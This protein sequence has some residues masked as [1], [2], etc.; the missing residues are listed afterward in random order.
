MKSS[1][2]LKL[3][4]LSLLWGGSFYFNEIALRE[5]PVFSVVAGRVV[6]AA[7]V[8]W[9]AALAS[10]YEVPASARDWGWFSVMAVVNNVIPFSLIVY[11]QTTITAG[12]ASILNATTPLFIVLVIALFIRNESIGWLKVAGLVVGFIGVGLM[13]GPEVLESDN[14]GVVGQLAILLAA[15]SYAVAGI[16]GRRFH[17]AS[18]P[19]IVAAAGQVTMSAVILIPVAMMIDGPDHLAAASGNAWMAVAGLAVLATAVAYILYFNILSSAGS[20]NLMLVTFLMPVTALLLGTYLLHEPVRPVE[21]TGM[22][23]IA[24]ALVIIDG[25]LLLKKANSPDGYR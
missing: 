23:I 13:L 24:V 16:Y 1:D 19:P 5:L 20:V 9:A 15:L 11:G 10:G 25:R 3:I 14:S 22:A 6:L 8:L 18:I 12:L 2:W 17:T 7:F 4:T 21:I